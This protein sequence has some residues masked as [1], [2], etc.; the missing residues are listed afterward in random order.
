MGLNG[1]DGREGGREVR[2]GRKCHGLG[3]NYCTSEGCRADDPGGF[4]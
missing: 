2:G 1:L 3:P 4:V